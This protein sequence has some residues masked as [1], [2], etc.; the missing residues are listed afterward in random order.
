MTCRNRDIQRIIFDYADG[1]LSIEDS[2]RIEE[3]LRECSEC[4]ELLQ[5][6]RG[7]IV[8]LKTVFKSDAQEHISD[9]TLVKYTDSP[10]AL[11]EA[12][13]EA[14]EFHLTVCAACENKAEMLRQ[15][16][17][18]E[19]SQTAIS[20]V[21]RLRSAFRRLLRPYD[22]RTKIGFA[23]ASLVAVVLLTIGI[24]SIGREPGSAMLVMR[25]T[26]AVW[27]QES[28]R[29]EQIPPSILE[30]DGWISV[31]V[32][33]NAFFDEESYT[34]Q[35]QSVEGKVITSLAITRN[36]YSDSGIQ[37]RIKTSSLA[38]GTHSLMLE[39]CKLTDKTSCIRTSYNFSLIRQ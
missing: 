6:Y 7:M 24:L 34:I 20:T 12:H 27:L 10:K 5:K 36:D 17:L 19:S 11:T 9:E 35:L 26:A 3:H 14:L 13:R 4:H 23:T 1:T 37:L 32:R 2:R 29:A 25:S 33:F 39:S 28:T 16:S 18:E 30:Q 15:V 22:Y 8:G 31:G 38:L 21:D